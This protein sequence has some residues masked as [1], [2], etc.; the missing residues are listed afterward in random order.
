MV[1]IRIYINIP[2]FK[3]QIIKSD[4]IMIWTPHI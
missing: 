2:Y 4:Y 3:I 1:M